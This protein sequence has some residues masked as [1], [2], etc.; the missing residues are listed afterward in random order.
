[1]QHVYNGYLPTHIVDTSSIDHLL[2]ILSAAHQF[3]LRTL[4]RHLVAGVARRLATNAE[5]VDARTLS[6]IVELSR[7]SSTRV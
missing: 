4:V 5:T 1:M 3:E 6:A 7:V 2:E